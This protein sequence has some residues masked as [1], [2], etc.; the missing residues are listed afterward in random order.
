MALRSYNFSTVQLIIGVA[1]I[2]GFGDDGGI[3]I[4]PSADHIVGTV[5][6]D[7]E[8]TISRLSDFSETATITLKET[9][10]SNAILETILAAQ[11]LL[12]GVAYNVPFLMSDVETGEKVSSQ[13]CA[14]MG[15]PSVGKASEAG[16]REWKV[17]LPVGIPTF[18]I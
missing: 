3:S 8:P 1:R 17:W 16:E 7:G 5:G 15:L 9:S 18:A 4:E 12:G 6:A 13:Q 11:T 2:G 10:L 14:I